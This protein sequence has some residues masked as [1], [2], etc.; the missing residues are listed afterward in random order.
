MCVCAVGFDGAVNQSILPVDQN[1]GFLAQFQNLDFRNRARAACWFLKN[2]RVCT[3]KAKMKQVFDQIRSDQ[4]TS[5]HT[6]AMLTFCSACSTRASEVEFKM[7]VIE[8]GANDGALT[9]RVVSLLL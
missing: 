3:K 2:G 8:D 5:D 9:A 7:S 1:T 6:T 4:I